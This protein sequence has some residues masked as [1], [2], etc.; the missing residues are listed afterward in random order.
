MEEKHEYESAHKVITV[1]KDGY[2]LF[3]QSYEYVGCFSLDFTI[4][5]NGYISG[6]AGYGGR[7]SMILE[8]GGG[9][10]NILTI[11]SGNEE[12]EIEWDK[13]QFDVCGGQEFKV[14]IEMLTNTLNMLKAFEEMPSLEITKE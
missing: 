8:N 12:K 10:G 4:A 11:R 7:V 13:I 6:D 9:F 3:G 1:T 5:T 14:L 2:E